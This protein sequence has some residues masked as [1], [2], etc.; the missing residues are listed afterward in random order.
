MLGA[1]SSVQM[2]YYTVF[3]P[4]INDT[5]THWLLANAYDIYLY[6][7]LVAA[8]PYLRNDERVVLWQAGYA[9][10]VAAVMETEMRGRINRSGQQLSMAAVSTP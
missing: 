6:G 4:L 10:A 1:S 8:E 3:G 7:S 2:T 9:D 5:D